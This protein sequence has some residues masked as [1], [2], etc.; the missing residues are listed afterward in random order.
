VSVN[1]INRLNRNQKTASMEVDSDKLRNLAE[2]PVCLQVRSIYFI[3]LPC[4]HT[5]CKGCYDKISDDV[6]VTC[7]LC[8][9]KIDSLGRNYD[10]EHLATLVGNT[11]IVNSVNIDINDSKGEKRPLLNRS[12]SPVPMRRTRFSLCYTATPTF[13]FFQFLCWFTFL[14]SLLGVL[15]FVPFYVSVEYTHERATTICLVNSTSVVP[16]NATIGD[17]GILSG[18]V[19]YYNVRFLNPDLNAFENAIIQEFNH[20][21]REVGQ[22]YICYYE[23]IPNPNC[24]P[25]SSTFA[26]HWTIDAFL[27][28]LFYSVIVIGSSCCLSM[29]SVLILIMIASC[30]RR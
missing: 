24:D 14:L 18:F 21:D 4:G 5:L 10:R 26:L 12:F 9:E 25:S 16:F 20:M 19:W 6:G 27:L 11:D 2:C 15:I 1:V 29:I 22:T 17:N 30:R 13:A 28:N 23:R 8:R 3:V 7:C